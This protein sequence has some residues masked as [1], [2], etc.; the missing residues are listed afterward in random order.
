MSERYFTIGMIIAL[1]AAVVLIKA[2]APDDSVFWISA[3]WAAGALACAMIVLVFWRPGT[4]STA[5]VAQ[6]AAALATIVAFVVAARI[7]FLESEDM[8]RLSVGLQANA[9]PMSIAPGPRTSVLLVVRVPIENRGAIAAHIHCTSIDVQRPGTDD[10]NRPVQ[11]WRSRNRDAREEVE[12]SSIG[13][14]IRHEA[15]KGQACLQGENR[16]FRRAVRPLFMWKSLIL[17]PGDQRDRYFEIPVACGVPFV[18]VIVKVRV[19]PGDVDNHEVKT[20]VP[21]IRICSG[22]EESS[23]GVSTPMSGGDPTSAPSPVQN[24]GSDGSANQSSNIQ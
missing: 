22:Q 14:A 16:Y 5:E 13:N 19:T 6:G 1:V 21:L 10:R 7:Y 9:V 8:V 23:A 2:V 15:E 12:L 24:V 18:R 3:K 20:I 4:A 11:N 17:Q